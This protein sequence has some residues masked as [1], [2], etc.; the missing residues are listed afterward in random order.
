M[1]CS[2][3]LE[4]FSAFSLEFAKKLRKFRYKETNYQKERK[5]GVENASKCHQ[6]LFLYNVAWPFWIVGNFKMQSTI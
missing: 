3:D 5:K 1:N 2:T 4:K 6:L